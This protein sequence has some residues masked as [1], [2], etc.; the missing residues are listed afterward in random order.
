MPLRDAGVRVYRAERDEE[1]GGMHF[2]ETIPDTKALMDKDG[3][4]SGMPSGIFVASLGPAFLCCLADGD[5][6]SLFVAAQSGTRWHYSLT[7]VQIMLV[8]ILFAILDALV[9]TGVSEKQGFG[10]MVR[11][12]FGTKCAVFCLCLLLLSCFGAIVSEMSGIS[13]VAALWGMSKTVASGATAAFVIIIVVFCNYRQVEMVALAFGLFELTF[14][15]VL[16][17]VW[18]PL[19]DIL[20][21]MISFEFTSTAWLRMLAANI[22]AVVMPWMLYFQQSAVVARRLTTSREVA[23]ERTQS[24]VGSFMAQLIMVATMMVLATTPAAIGKN[25]DS[26]LDIQ[27]AI[28]PFFGVMAAKVMVSLAFFGG[29]VCAVF[30]VSL[31]AAWA[32]CDTIGDGTGE[33]FSLD[34]KLSEAPCFYSSFVIMVV[35]G[36]LVLLVSPNIVKLN[37]LIEMLNAAMIPIL[38]LFLYLVVTGPSMHPKLVI[39]GLHKRVLSV[40]FFLTSAVALASTIASCLLEEER[41]AAPPI[42]LSA[43]QWQSFRG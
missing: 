40:I 31:A 16:F 28:Q 30:V 29:S 4:D 1:Q 25:L 8:P 23:L 3:K 18:P 13:S 26:I 11:V 2:L 5:A 42:L 24:L 20:R 41:P 35:S 15:A 43:E 12:H 10:A 7:L 27:M 36:A 6:G 34:K 37:V 32:F 19:S 39:V 22:G 38:L 17:Y 33:P 9:R 21:G 14:V